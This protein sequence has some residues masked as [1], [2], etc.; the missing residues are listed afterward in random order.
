MQYCSKLV[1]INPK[2]QKIDFND[3][4]LFHFSLINQNLTS[5]FLGILSGFFLSNSISP[6]YPTTLVIIFA[7]SMIYI[8]MPIIQE[9]KDDY[10]T[11]W[12][13]D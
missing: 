11:F 9:K 3:L 6:S 2:H 13:V 7:R 8:Q 12:I 1:S 5:D 10:D 4:A